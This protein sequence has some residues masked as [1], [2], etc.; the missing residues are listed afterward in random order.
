MT[1]SPPT[2]LAVAGSAW[3]IWSFAPSPWFQSNGIFFPVD[4][5]LERLDHP[6]G[7]DDVLL[8]VDGPGRDH[9]RERAWSVPTV[10]TAF[11]AAMWAI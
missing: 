1:T 5:L 9:G 6:V 10:V 8:A 2:F 11:K 4:P 3:P 7:V